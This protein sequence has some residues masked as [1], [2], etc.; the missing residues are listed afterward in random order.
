MTKNWIVTKV[1][2]K[3]FLRVGSKIFK[4]QIGKTGNKIYTKKNEGD[5]ATP[6]GKWRLKSI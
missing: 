5:Q 2:K 1:N 6:I 4:C 3:F